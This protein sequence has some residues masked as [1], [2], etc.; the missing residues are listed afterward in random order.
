M[1][2]LLITESSELSGSNSKA[3]IVLSSDEA[4]FSVPSPGENALSIDVF[5]ANVCAS[6]ML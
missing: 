1:F 4:A 6:F 2:I 3:F 5:F